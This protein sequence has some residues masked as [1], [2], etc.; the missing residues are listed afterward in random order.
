[1]K[2]T[3]IKVPEG[4]QYISEWGEYQLPKG[5]HCIVNKG[6]TGCG[7]TEFCLG[8]YDNVVLCSPR[9][10]LLENKRDQHLGDPGILYLENE[11]TDFSSSKTMGSKVLDH[12]TNCKG[13]YGNIP[14]KIMVTY[15]SCHYVVETLKGL[16]LLGEFVFVADE[17]QSIFS[18]AFFKSDVELDF[19]SVL[20]ECPS[21]IYLSATP[22]LEKYLDRLSEF[23]DLPM[24]ILDW[25]E[26]GYVENVVLKR[27]NTNSLSKEAKL[28]IDNYKSGKFP[29]TLDPTTGKPVESK[30]AVFYLNS[31]SEILR[32]VS[33]KGLTS[34]NTII[35]C[36]DTPENQAKLKKKG[37]S[38][39]KVPLKGES[40]PMFMFCTSTSYVGVDMYSDCAST[41]IFSDPNITSLATD[42][43]TDLSQ[44]VG[45]QR[46]KSNLFKNDV[47]IFYKTQKN[48]V[49]REDF[50]KLQ[51]ERKKSTNII[52]NDFKNLTPQGKIEYVKKLRSDIQLRKYSDDFVAVSSLTN[53]PVYNTLVEI[54]NERAW[55]VSQKDYQD[56]I[57]I[58]RALKDAGFCVETYTS[59]QDQIVSEFLDYHFYSTG[60]FT[61]KMR[62]YCEFRDK[63][64]GDQEVLA[65]LN[66]K[67]DDQKFKMYYEY[68]GTSGCKSRGY[69]E[70][71]LYRGWK[72]ITLED[73]LQ[74]KILLRFKIG[75]RYSKSEI[76]EVLTKFREELGIS[77]VAK[78]TD[79]GRYFKLTKT[80]ITNSD[81]TVVNGFKLGKL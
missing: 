60:I 51:E 22:M 25:K 30:E 56:N 28:I 40:Y 63:Y 81:K 7:Y 59:E 46:N 73:Q 34:K 47:T 69:R 53:L 39:G 26:T 10:L 62:M 65:A 44:I 43:Y 57:S 67:I 36:S 49:T 45:R 42:I 80:S 21:V 6:V 17:F 52:L 78:A 38:V 19:V 29:M 2:T 74:E 71:D 23:K 18:D 9:K 15:D 33:S 11:V 12:W 76:K 31:V 55:E 77:G 20:Q 5:H 50:D 70:L 41:Y 68:Y 75:G 32:I 54:S 79:L 3:E 8:N 16:G 72:N 14:C 24:Y 35:I 48:T 1:M 37:F 27:K 64:F 4:I 13:P 58:T 61:E 66:A